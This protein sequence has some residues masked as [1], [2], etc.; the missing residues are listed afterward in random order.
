[1]LEGFVERWSG[2]G[3]R[4]RQAGG[5]A[6]KARVDRLQGESSQAVKDETEA[7]TIFEEIGDKTEVARMDLHLAELFL[8][9]GKTKEAAIAARPAADVFEKTKA[10]VDEAAAN[11]LLAKMLLVDGR[12]A[13]ARNS[14]SHVMTMATQTHNPELGLSA[15]L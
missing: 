14:V 13:D 2:I 10:T 1:M 4:S 5:R 11:L 3:N 9:E 15:P 12:I 6:G 7:R 8:D